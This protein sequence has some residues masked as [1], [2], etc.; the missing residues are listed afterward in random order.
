MRTTRWLPAVLL[1]AL[2]VALSARTAASAQKP[3]P[4]I[5]EQTVTETRYRWWLVPWADSSQPACTIDIYHPENPL[6]EEIYRAC[7]WDLYHAWRATPACDA[8]VSG[9]DVTACE[10][11]Y[12][13]FVG[14]KEVTH[15]VKHWYPLP[16]ATLHLQNCLA[17]LPHF[18]CASPVELH[19]EGIEP[20]PKAAI[21]KVEVHGPHD[22]QVMC[23]EGECT[24]T[25]PEVE[26]ARQFN[27]TFRAYSTWGNV[28]PLYHAQVRITPQDDGVPLVD[29]ISAQWEDPGHDA[30]AQAGAVFPDVDGLPAWTRTPDDPA[31]LA[32]DQ[33]YALLAAR[34]I[35]N[36]VVDA[37]D[38]P[39][40]GLAEGGP[41]PC[42]MA[43]AREIVTAWQNRFDP[44]LLETARD[45]GIPAVLFKRIIAHES[46]FWPATYPER[47]EVGF[48][49]LS[50]Q[51]M[52]TILLWDKPYFDDLCAQTL[53]PWVC[54]QGYLRLDDQ[55]KALLY[56][57]IW[58]QADLTC[59]DCPAGIDGE[60]VPESLEMF[61]RLVR[62]YC[63]QTSQLIHNLTRQPAGR[64]VSYTDLWRFT[65]A[66][67]NGPYCFYEALATTRKA[68]QPL[69]WD[70]VQSHLASSCAGV[71]NYVESIAP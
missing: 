6:P 68:H 7:G 41:N 37:S 3:P 28:T 11:Y 43:R 56:G 26:K 42:G 23:Y 59:S 5:V 61:A 38:C 50:P 45:I 19:I 2:I 52:D 34:L 13:F 30:C 64:N 55:A 31:A 47:Y 46:Q 67:Y 53:A 21:E 70:N 49:Q 15:T 54:R 57:A 39:N 36:G 51:G 8:A 29:V 69:T 1:A 25:F 32:T 33:P 60:R 4:R 40:G 35:A 17:D 24:V 65:L 58:V 27:L 62:S 14:A 16:T 44:Y 66:D 9:G 63:Y 18:R 48:G 20:F 71:R 10:G 12:L 22:I